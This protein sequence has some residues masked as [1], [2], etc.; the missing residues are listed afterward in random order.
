VIARRLPALAAGSLAVLVGVSLFGASA[1]TNTVPPTRAGQDDEALL[2]DQL[3]PPECAGMGLTR[4]QVGGSGSGG[5][6]ALIVGTAGNDTLNGGGGDDCIVA[7]GGSDVLNGQGGDDVL[8]S[9]PGFIDFLNGGGGT[10]TCYGKGFL[11]IPS[12]CENY[13]P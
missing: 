1:A 10:D 8:I 4:L 11:N 9:G 5:G 7:G 6:N 3:A 13:I 12:S 2:L